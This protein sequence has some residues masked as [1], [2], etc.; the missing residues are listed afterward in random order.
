MTAT[1]TLTLDAVVGVPCPLRGLSSGPP[2]GYRW[3]LDLPTG[4]A[5]VAEPAGQAAPVAVAGVSALGTGSDAVP[6]V[7]ASQP[8]RYEIPA[9]LARPWEPDAPVRSVRVT[10]NVRA[11][12]A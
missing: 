9:R 10:L 4:L 12:P 3:M 6:W 8:G 2:S 7:Q 11:A 1:D 5:S